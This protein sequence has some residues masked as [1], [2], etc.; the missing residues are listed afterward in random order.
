MK[1]S[2]KPVRKS[3]PKSA[4]KKTA[5]PAKKPTMKMAAPKSSKK[6]SKKTAKKPTKKPAMKA[7]AP[8]ASKAMKRVSAKK[9]VAAKM[10]SPTSM[11]KPSAG[12][13]I[14]HPLLGQSAPNFSV[15]NDEGHSVSLQDYRGKKVVLYFYPKDD[16]PGCTQEACDFRDSWSRVQATGA[17]VLGV[18]RDSV[19]SHQKFRQ[20][21]SLPYALLA[22]EEGKVCESFGVWKEKSNYGKTSMGIER[23]TFVIDETGNVQKVWPKVRVEGHI[24]EILG[25]LN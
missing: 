9:P 14:S 17:V 11:V 3:A 6:S 12:V 22:D 23:T 19:E 13:L 8:K 1:K 21:Y 24:D 5:K 10:K 2:K 16:T 20:K 25:E 7:S 4:K 18:S 15:V